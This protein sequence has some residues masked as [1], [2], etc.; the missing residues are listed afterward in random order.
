MRVYKNIEFKKSARKNSISDKDL[1][2][3]A[4][5]IENGLVDAA[6]GAGVLKKRVSGRGKGKSGGFRTL[7]FSVRVSA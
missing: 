7:V 2:A 3:Y 6:L 1:L 5:E 4:A